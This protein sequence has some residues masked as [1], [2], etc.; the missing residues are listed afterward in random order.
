[1][2]NK[3]FAAN[4]IVIVKVSEKALKH[5]NREGYFAFSY[6][7]TGQIILRDIHNPKD[8]FSIP[9]EDIKTLRK[10]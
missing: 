10:I 3:F 2:E 4:T 1:M 9:E 8:I 6:C 5:A 7:P